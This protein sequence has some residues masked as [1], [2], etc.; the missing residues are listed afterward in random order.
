M[1]LISK[2]PKYNV[3]KKLNEKKQAF[4]A[5]KT[6]KLKDEREEQRLK[7]KQ[8]KE[9]LEKFLMSTDK[10][11]SNTKYYKCDEMF[12]NMDVWK[13]VPEPD[14][15]DIYE[16]CIFNLAKQEKEEAKQM[17]KR[18]MKSLG[19]LLESMTSITYQTKWSEAQVLLLD[20]KN[21]KN[22]INLL[23]MDKEDA[24]IVFEGHIKQLERE[25]EEEKEREKKRKR[26]QERKNRDGFLGLLDSLH[27]DGKLTSMSFW[28][29][30]YPIISADIRFS[31]MLGQPG[32][33]PLDLF[34]IYVENL[35]D[36]FFDEKEIVKSI[37]KKRAFV[38]KSDTT[39]TEFATLVCED[40]RSA[41][42]DAG[43]VKLTFNSLLEKAE[44][45][46][47]ERLK[48][49]SRR[50]RK[51]ENELK[52]I[53][54]DAGLQTTD[55]WED[56]LKLVE[57]KEVFEMYEKEK[58]VSDLWNEFIKESEDAC[59]HHHSKSKKSKKNRKHK[60]RSRTSSVSVS[61]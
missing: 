51:M 18:N 44:A 22:D 50:I 59:T 19:E 30:L 33:T 1:K 41:N 52:N 38:V 24:L 8:S 28:V 25:E 2:D 40:E 48:E 56:A 45:A 4:N 15:R 17:K 49:E 5:Y 42:L 23:A 53:W 12:A 37:L 9:N 61:N 47:K 20:N 36:R 29:E 31:A 32:S 21:F 55:S 26:R 35:R 54:V 7:V 11:D 16:D 13:F 6:Q 39:F 58:K 60:K 43:N 14:R 27:E 3:F 10:I 34:K 46:E 57:D